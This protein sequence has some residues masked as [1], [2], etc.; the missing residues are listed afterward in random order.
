MKARVRND[1]LDLTKV[2]WDLC[3]LNTLHCEFGFGEKRI[4]K[5]YEKL[6][7]TQRWFTEYSCATDKQQSTYTNMD[8]AIIR[9]INDL[10]GIDWQTI[11]NVE[12]IIFKGKDI[13]KIGDICKDR[14]N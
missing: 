10:D 13:I 7:E 4:K 1:S 2:I 5:F 8:T 14:R 11:L 3:L 9:L 6:E 12:G